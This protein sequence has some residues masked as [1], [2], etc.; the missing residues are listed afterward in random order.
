M[1]YGNICYFNNNS[2]VRPDGI[3]K[4]AFDELIKE[5]D[6]IKSTLESRGEKF[7]ANNIVVFDEVNKI[8]GE[9]DILSVTK[10]GKFNNNV[11][12]TDCTFLKRN[13]VFLEREQRWI[14]PLALTSIYK[15]FE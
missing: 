6:T 5:L 14:A 1:G 7:L 15:S 2:T 11:S 13:F 10:D 12:I 4:E 9:L 3:S 8:A